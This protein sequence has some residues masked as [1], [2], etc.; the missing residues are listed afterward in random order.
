M[1]LQSA[2]ET[3][4]SISP[5]QSNQISPFQLGSMSDGVSAVLL[6]QVAVFT[7]PS[8]QVT[9]AMPITSA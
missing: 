3:P 6:P 5:W 8:G 2:R 1:K 4:T 7:V 9:S